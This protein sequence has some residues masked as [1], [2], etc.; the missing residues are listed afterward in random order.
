MKGIG[1]WKG[2]HL[3]SRTHARLPSIR[4]FQPPAANA[5]LMVSLPNACGNN[6]T[7]FDMLIK[8]A[9]LLSFPEI[10]G[11]HPVNKNWEIGGRNPV[12]QRCQ[13]SHAP[14]ILLQL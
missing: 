8:I 3:A 7:K 14:P 10:S 6:L 4:T 9:S 13:L 12:L 2:F 11:R 5:S 1:F